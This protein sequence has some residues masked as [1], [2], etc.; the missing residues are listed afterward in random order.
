VAEIASCQVEVAERMNKKAKILKTWGLM[1]AMVLLA[2]AVTV[3][4]VPSTG[5]PRSVAKIVL[6]SFIGPAESAGTRQSEEKEAEVIEK[7]EPE[8]PQ[9]LAKIATKT[10]QTDKSIL[11]GDGKDETNITSSLEKTIKYPDD[12]KVF[13]SKAGL[14]NLLPKLGSAVK[15][16]KIGIFEEAL[17]QGYQLLRLDRLPSKTAVEYA[18]FAWKEQSGEEPEWL[19]IWRP[20]LS[21]SDFYYGYRS[22]NIL[23]LQKM[24]KRLGYYWGPDDGMVGPVTWRAINGFQKDMKL[25][26]TMWPDPETIFWLTVMAAQ[27]QPSSKS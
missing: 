19:V 14:G 21:V 26:R 11:T 5:G 4:Y 27:P 20:S 23:V 13:L 10:E 12:Y 17:P 9:E 16:K 6:S 7:T 18:A 3:P 22:E 1:A 25:K 8:K 15:A 2:L 24:L